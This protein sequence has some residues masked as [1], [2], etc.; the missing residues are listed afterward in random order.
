MLQKTLYFLGFLCLYGQIGAVDNSLVESLD[1]VETFDEANPFETGKWVLSTNSKYL[2]QPV[3][4]MAAGDDVIGQE[5]D[6]G[7][8][9]TQEMK[10]YGF[11]AKM[12]T[13][14][15][16]G[17][18]K[19]LIVQYEL[20]FVDTLNCGG[21]YIKLLRGGVESISQLDNSSP[22][23][24]MFGPDRCGGTNK[25]HFIVQHRNPVTDKWEEKHFNE[26]IPVKSD[27]KTHLYS[28]ILRADNS[29]TILVDN[30]LAREGSLLTHMTPAINPP[31]QIDDPT[32]LKVSLLCY[33]DVN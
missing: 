7:V 21:A 32:D 6:K 3:K 15:A 13:P 9:L 11:G 24:I 23:T 27:K 17:G 19:D 26:T 33:T 2:G 8:Q 29:F 14:I 20:K 22:Y 10:H 30:K 28:L 31:A 16:I 25:V 1:F 4:V 5:N 12:A 18:G